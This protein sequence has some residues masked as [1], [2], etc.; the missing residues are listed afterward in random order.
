MQNGYISTFLC[1]VN[2]YITTFNLWSLL[3]T[4]TDL[5]LYIFVMMYKLRKYI[6]YYMVVSVMVIGVGNGH[7]DTSSN[8]GRDWLHFT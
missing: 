5:V 4:S 1:D 8:P 3:Q 6:K 2:T 7:S